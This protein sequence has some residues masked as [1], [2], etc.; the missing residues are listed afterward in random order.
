MPPRL[1]RANLAEGVSD[2]LTQ[3]RLAD[4]GRSKEA[5]DG[6]ASGRVEL[7]DGKVFD[8]ALL[9]LDE[10]EVIAVEDFLRLGR[11]DRF[12]AENVPRKLG[13]GLPGS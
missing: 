1:I 4:T 9:D 8:E 2:G 5:E 6:P 3:A 12:L 11:I 10:A 7:A 13:Q